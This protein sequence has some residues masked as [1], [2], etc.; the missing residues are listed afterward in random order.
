[1]VF[2]HSGIEIVAAATEDGRV[3]LLDASVLGGADHAT[4]LMSATF[5]RPAA[6]EGLATFELDGTR[7]LLVPSGGAIAAFKV[8]V[9]GNRLS[10]QQGWTSRALSAPTAP[11]VV[12]DVVFAAASGRS[13]GSA[14]LYAFEARTGR[15]IW[16]SGTT[17]GS[18]IPRANLW[19]S[20][21]QVYVGTHDGA[22]YAFGF[23]LERR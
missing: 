5:D 23:E 7:W 22:V 12:N 10:L 4:P 9:D 6:P 16:N 15:E 11:I 1:V 18:Q 20:N 19:A 14:V 13:G 2:T 21:S 17:I 3:V 8:A